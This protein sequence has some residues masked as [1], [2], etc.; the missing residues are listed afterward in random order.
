MSVENL[1]YNTNYFWRVRASNEAGISNWSEAR[2]FTTKSE[3]LL[4]PETPA[5]ASPEDNRTNESRTPV[6]SW[7]AVES[8]SFYELRV[9]GSED[10]VNP[11]FSLSDITE[12]EA[13]AEGLNYETTYFWQV[14]AVNEAGTSG[15]SQVWSFTTREEPLTAPESPEPASP[16]N[17]SNGV[18]ESPFLSWSNSEDAESYRLQVSL[19][20]NFTPLRDLENVQGTS[21][22]VEELDFETTYFWRVQAVNGAGESE[23]SEI[24]SFTTRE[25]PLSVPEVPR[26]ISPADDEINVSL[27][28]SFSW[29]EASDAESYT[30]Q[31]TSSDSLFGSDV[32]EFTNISETE[33]NLEGLEP[34]T[35]YH[36]RVRSVNSAG[37]SGWSEPWAFVTINSDTDDGTDENTFDGNDEELVTTVEQNFPNPFNP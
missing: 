35:R 20:S 37:E 27:N 33:M 16:A 25:E 7:L 2:S 23:W 13:I 17:G 22:R 19:S 26:L 30:F 28:V 9:A 3:P 36:W 15:W 34:L 21:V 8:A 24:W 12:T 31:L 6:L 5:L 4:P 11:V 1:N 18:S 29:N 14:R 32:N 10:F